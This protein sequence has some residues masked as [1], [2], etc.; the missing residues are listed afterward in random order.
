MEW[1]A[2]S[3]AQVADTSWQFPGPVDDVTEK[4]ETRGQE[5]D[6]FDLPTKEE[7]KRNCPLI[8]T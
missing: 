5:V 1:E 2:S 7:P 8:A 4:H 3:C 6:L